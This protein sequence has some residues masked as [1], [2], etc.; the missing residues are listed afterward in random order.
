MTRKNTNREQLLDE[1][2]GRYKVALQREKE[3]R[4][5]DTDTLGRAIAQ[6][7]R[8]IE[9]KDAVIRKMRTAIQVMLNK[10]GE[11]VSDSTIVDSAQISLFEEEEHHDK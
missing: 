4:G 9:R 1:S 11:A 7:A 6:M 5:A 10:I 2:L 3:Q 8:E